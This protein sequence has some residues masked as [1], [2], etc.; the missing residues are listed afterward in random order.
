MPIT[1]NQI[2][3]ST[4]MIVTD[5]N[6]DEK[7]T[8]SFTGEDGEC[9]RYFDFTTLNRSKKYTTKLTTKEYMNLDKSITCD[10]QVK[11][12]IIIQVLSL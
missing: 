10:I 5:Y 7:L 3:E 6:I 4:A 1:P 11:V 2:I 8:F 12:F 9:M